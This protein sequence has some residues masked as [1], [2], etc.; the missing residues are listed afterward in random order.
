MDLGVAEPKHAVHSTL[1]TSTLPSMS[2]D[3]CILEI[4]YQWNHRL[5]GPL[6]M[7]FFP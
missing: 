5:R 3:L 4:S 6:Y 1:A 7:A 2:M